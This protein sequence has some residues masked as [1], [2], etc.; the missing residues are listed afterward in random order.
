MTATKLPPLDDRKRRQR[1]GLVR[2]VE[3]VNIATGHVFSA[4]AVIGVLGIVV[5][6]M[7]AFR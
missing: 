4:I 1:L 6:L 3:D 7:L 5:A 2:C